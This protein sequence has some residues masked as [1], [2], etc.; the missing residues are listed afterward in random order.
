MY[1]T[2]LVRFSKLLLFKTQTISFKTTKIWLF[3]KFCVI[4]WA[5]TY[6]RIRADRLSSEALFDE[7]L[8]ILSD[9][10][11]VHLLWGQLLRF[12][13]LPG[14]LPQRFSQQLLPDTW[15][16]GN[17]QCT[18]HYLLQQCSYNYSRT[19]PFSLNNGNN[20]LFVIYF[21]LAQ[22]VSTNLK[23]ITTG[24]YLSIDDV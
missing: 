1:A 5:W 24:A 4:A 21:S 11:L 3:L 22:Y 13:L 17:K 6:L 14:L 10:L 16:T 15:R 9:G 7:A 12:H 19:A 8:C 18:H 20:T 2:W 23:Y